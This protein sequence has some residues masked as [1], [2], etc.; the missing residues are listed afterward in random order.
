MTGVGFV[1]QANTNIKALKAANDYC[2]KMNKH[3]VPTN[4]A[5]SGVYGW[6]PRQNSLVFMCIHENDPGY[7][8]PDLPSP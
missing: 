7:T 4:S 8:Q 6:S 1:T 3:M 5:E 2:A